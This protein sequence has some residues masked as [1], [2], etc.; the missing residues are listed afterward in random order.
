M[1]RIAWTIIALVCVA[2]GLP[3]FPGIQLDASAPATHDGSA[4]CEIHRRRGDGR[5]HLADERRHAT[6][7]TPMFTG[8]S[9]R[10]VNTF[11]VSGTDLSRRHAARRAATSAAPDESR[12]TGNCHER[13]G[14]WVCRGTFNLDIDRDRRGWSSRT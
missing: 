2:G 9:D 8:R 7:S 11:I 5:P 1:K 6:R 10:A 14:T 3:L 4:R 13:I 12:R